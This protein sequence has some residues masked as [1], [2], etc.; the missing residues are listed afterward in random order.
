MNPPN[1]RLVVRAA[2]VALALLVIAVSQQACFLSALGRG[3]VR[4]DPLV[5]ADV[6]VVLSGDTPAR[7]LAAADLFRA[8]CPPRVLVTQAPEKPAIREL[9]ARGV[10][11]ELEFDR[12]LRYL[13]ELG[14]P[15]SALVPLRTTV[16]TTTDEAQL[17]AGWCRD[18]K[19]GRLIVVTSNYHTRRAGYIF[20]WAMKGQNAAIL[21]HAATLVAFDPN[22]W[23]QSRPSLLM[24][25]MEWQKTVFYR[26]RYW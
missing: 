12:Q 23:W 14:V 15:D 9:L 8:G 26:L 2:V 10:D 6:I 24:G 25:L 21:V 4:S 13:R 20:K 22:T 18:H 16:Q 11:A 1:R 7:E 17:V 5:K 19:V 3:L